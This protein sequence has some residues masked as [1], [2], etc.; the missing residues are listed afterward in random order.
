MGG[1]YVL[2]QT[3]YHY[4]ALHCANKPTMPDMPGPGTQLLPVHFRARP[5]NP[6]HPHFYVLQ[7]NT[8]LARL[9]PW[10]SQIKIY[11]A[12]I[13]D[14]NHHTKGLGKGLA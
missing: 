6:A 1:I 14:N 11:F 4:T 5:E 8:V 3:V 10:N 9:R 12:A 13:Q 7:L 2:S